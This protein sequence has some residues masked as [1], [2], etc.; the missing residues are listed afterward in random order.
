MSIKDIVD[1][2]NLAITQRGGYDT[3]EHSNHQSGN[4]KY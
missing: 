3:N 4:H 2:R 1:C